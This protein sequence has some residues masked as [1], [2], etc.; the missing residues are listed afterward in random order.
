MATYR[1]GVNDPKDPHAVVFV[2]CPSDLASS[3]A[4]LAAKW[5]KTGWWICEWPIAGEPHEWHPLMRVV[6]WH[7]VRYIELGEQ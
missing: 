7:M 2:T 3:A 6:P 5:A 1:V 4:D